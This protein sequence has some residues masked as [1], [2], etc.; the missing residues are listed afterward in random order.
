MNQIATNEYDEAMSA[1]F[2]IQDGELS[3]DDLGM[4]T[5]ADDD[6]RG[7]V[8]DLESRIGLDVTEF[9]AAIEAFIEARS[10]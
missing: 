8:D 2:D 10:A 5:A 4:E 6:L 1:L 9:R 3:E 7:W